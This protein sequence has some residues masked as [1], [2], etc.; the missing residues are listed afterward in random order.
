M[1]GP[2][3]API[4]SAVD[5]VKHM[6]DYAGVV[7]EKQNRF[8]AL[9][10]PNIWATDINGR[11]ITFSDQQGTVVLTVGADLLFGENTKEKVVQWAW[12][13]QGDTPNEAV[14]ARSRAL[15]DWGEK[16]EFAELTMGSWK[17]DPVRTGPALA[18]VA[19][20]IGNFDA[21]FIAPDP[22]GATSYFAVTSPL[23]TTVAFDLTAMARAICDMCNGYPVE[24]RRAILAYFTARGLSITQ[25]MGRVVG[26]TP[27]GAKIR[28]IFDELGRIKN[29]QGDFAV[30]EG[31]Q[32]AR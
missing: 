23:V 3:N 5:F 9:V 6:A 24:H 1:H 7:I 28:V 17:T 19:A 16:H 10:G 32:L 8:A 30:P 11:Q 27:T 22:D 12:D 20:G 31:L 13:M 21:I 18:C 29:L 25:P 14:K 15:R 26:V 4:L 2:Q